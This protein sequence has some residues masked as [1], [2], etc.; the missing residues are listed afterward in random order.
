MDNPILILAAIAALF[1]LAIWLYRSLRRDR[2]A[3]LMARSRPGATICSRAHLIDGGSHIP[4][5][6]TLHPTQVHYASDDLDGSVDIDRIDEVEYA[7]D[8][9]SGGI[10]SGA[11]LR[12]RAHGRAIEFIL[13]VT[14]AEEWSQHL[15]PHRFGEAGHV[16]A[17]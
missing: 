9:V 10:A 17:V 11:V 6:L 2:F 4:V 14:A 12:L 7:S 5:A 8:M 1:A 3:E 15:P 13:D 16:H